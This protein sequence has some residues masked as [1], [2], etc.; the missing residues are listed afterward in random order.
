MNRTDGGFYPKVFALV[1]AGILGYALVRMALPFAGPILW[2][3]LLAFLLYPLN[4]A[5][6]RALAR[7]RGLAALLLTLAGILLIVAPAALIAVAFAT[8]AKDLVAHIQDIAERQHISKLSDLLQIPFAYRIDRMARVI[9]ADQRRSGPGLAGRERPQLPPHTGGSERGGAGQR[10]RRGGGPRADAVPAL[11]LPARRRGDGARSMRLVPM[12]EDRKAALLDHLSSVTRALVLGMLLTAVAQGALLGTGFAIVGLPSPVVFGVLAALASVVPFV[13]TALVWVPAVLVLLVQGRT[14]AALFLLI[15]S[16]GLVTSVDNVIKPLVV[17]GRAGLPTFAVFLG[18]VGG[19]A[20]FGAI[21]MFLGPVI[22]ALTIALLRFAGE[23]QAAERS[24]SSAGTAGRL[25]NARSE[26]PAWAGI[27]TNGAHTGC[28]RDLNRRDSP[29][30]GSLTWRSAIISM[31]ANLAILAG[32]PPR[33]DWVPPSAAAASSEI[34]DPDAPPDTPYRL[35][36]YLTFGAEIE[37]THEYRKNLGL[38]DRPDNDASL[39]EP[40]LSLAFSFDPDPRFQAFLNVAVSREF[41]WKIEADRAKPSEDVSFTIQEAFVW[42]RAL[43]G[44]LSLQLGRQR[45]EDERQWLYD[46]ELDAVRVRYERGALAVELSA[47]RD[48]LVRK[49]ALS[50]HTPIGSTTTCCSRT[51]VPSKT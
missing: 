34:F 46:E 47:G 36:P 26:P 37:F 35:A 5:L 31:A 11:L 21:G 33:Q 2:A 24:G 3:L 1:T 41:V 14:W 50:G 20:A 13:G 7:R 43:P 17:S 9:P 12:E 40:E 49:N 27:S 22:V 44:G 45:F 42:L 16:V 19:L 32:L 29:V 8:Q 6:G 15:W 25:R 10:G 38:D 39:F 23:S 51:T 30:I 28:T 4:D 48:G 18:L